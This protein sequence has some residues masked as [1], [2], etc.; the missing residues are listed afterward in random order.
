MIHL[1]STLLDIPSNT[2]TQGSCGCGCGCGAEAGDGYAAGLR[3]GTHDGTR[4][5]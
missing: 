2:P 1:F 4:D 3:Q 5:S